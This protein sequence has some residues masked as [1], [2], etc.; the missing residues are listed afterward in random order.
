MAL[1]HARNFIVPGFDFLCITMGKE[2][3]F[4]REKGTGFFIF[5][6]TETDAIYSKEVRIGMIKLN[7]VPFPSSE[8][9]EIVPPNFSI[10]P[11]QMA[12]PKP[13]PC[14]F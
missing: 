6:E 14:F 7:V 1:L 12:N 13:K 8:A 10:I 2:G 5:C 9:T 3:M 4:Y 11:L